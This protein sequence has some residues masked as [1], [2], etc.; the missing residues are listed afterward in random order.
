MTDSGHDIEGCLACDLND[1]RRDLPGTASTPPRGAVEA[2][3][4]RARQL[5]GST[6]VIT[7]DV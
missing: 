7:S 5:L 1:G 2:F 4:E 3:A 6:P